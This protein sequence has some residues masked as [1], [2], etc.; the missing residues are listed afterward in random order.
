[1]LPGAQLFVTVTDLSQ[2]PAA[3]EKDLRLIF[4]LSPAEANVAALLAR[5]C[6]V[7]EIAAERG[8]SIATVRTQIRQVFQ[9][10]EVS[11]IGELVSLVANINRLKD[12]RG[13][14]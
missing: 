1:M 10:T 14:K 12:G 3:A 6:D 2:T 9:K 7:E 13:R 5:G 4:A 8:T 11:R